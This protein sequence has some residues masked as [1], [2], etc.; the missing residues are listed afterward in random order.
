MNDSCSTTLNHNHNY[1]SFHTPSW[2]DTT[3][4]RP[5]I[6]VIYNLTYGRIPPRPLG[7]GDEQKNLH[8]RTGPGAGVRL[9][10]VPITC[11]PKYGPHYT[12]RRQC[13][14]DISS[15][16][17]RPL[18]HTKR[19]RVPVST[20]PMKLVPVLVNTSACQSISKQIP[21]LLARTCNEININLRS[22][23]H[24]QYHQQ[25]RLEVLCKQDISRKS[26]H[27]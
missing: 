27:N 6:P 26:T 11:P 3:A 2:I 25:V 15:P 14:A 20:K 5:S 17:T 1:G 19:V 23:I 4:L 16:S 13:T 21:N 22:C 12:V 18:L 8:R 9:T 10:L 7:Y 24:H